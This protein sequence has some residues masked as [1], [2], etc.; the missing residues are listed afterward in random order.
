MELLGR[1]DDAIAVEV[2]GPGETLTYRQLDER[3]RALA[4]RLRA[5]GAGP[6]HIIPVAL[7]RGIELIVTLVGILR[8]GAAYAPMDPAT[9]QA[10]R[11]ELARL[12]GDAAQA[13]PHPARPSHPQDLAYLIF[14]SGSTGTPKAVAVPRSALDNHRRAMINA[15]GLTGRDR[16]VQFASPA[17]DVL[18][19]EVFPTLAVGARLVILPDSL[20]G[21]AEFERLV[22]LHGITVANL[23]T[24]YWTEWTRDLDAAPR[25]L[26]SSLRLLVIGS[27]GGHAAT[28]RS[29]RA[30]TSIPVINAYGLSETTITTAL[31][32]LDS[33]EVSDPLPIGSAIDGARLYVLDADLRPVAPG[34]IGEL[35]V[36]GAVLARGYLGRP[37]LTADRFVPDPYAPTPGERLYRTGDLVREIAGQGLQFLGRN[38]EQIKI[39]GHRVEPLEVQSALVSHPDVAAAHIT[40]YLD[41]RETRLVAYL[42]PGTDRRVPTATA[43]R[44]HLAHRLPDYFLPSAYVILDRLPLLPNGKVDRSALPPVS[45][46]RHAD[47]LTAPRTPTEEALARVWCEVLG[48]DA[49]GVDEDLF[50][51][52]GHSL[53]A[54]RLAARIHE[55]TGAGVTAVQILGAPTIAAV[56]E[57]VG[58]GDPGRLPALTGQARTTAPLSRQQEQVC[59]LTN[60]APHSIAYHTQ[61]TI[62]VAG[63]LDLEVLDRTIT[64]LVRR[65]AIFRTTY[66]LRDGQFQQHI[67]DPAP[68]A[69]RRVDLR[70]VAPEQRESEVEKHVAEEL[71]RPFDLTA[72]PLLRWTVLTLADD[73]HEIVLVEHHL[74]HDGW[75]FALLMREFKAIYNAYA[76]GEPSPLPEPTVQY[77]DY[78]A[79]QSRALDTGELADQLDYWRKRL[80]G[81]PAAL[82][83]HPDR[84]R[85]RV[86]TYRGGTLRIELPPTL[87]AAVRAFCRAERVTLF[88]AMYAAFAALMHRYTGVTDVCIGSAYANRQVPGTQKI[89]G[90]FVNAVLLRTDVGPDTAY[91]DLAHR[92]QE[93]ILSAADHQ[94]LPFTEL[95][96]VLNPD[97]D[98]AGQPLM[99]I[100]FSANDSPL[101]DLDLAG[102]AATVFERGNGSAKMDID[103]VVIPRAE[104]QT[105]DAEHV[106]DRIMLLWE[107]NADLYEESTMHHMIGHYLNLLAAAVA[108]PDTAVADLPLAAPFVEPHRPAAPFVPVAQQVRATPRQAIGSLS[109]VDLVGR[110]NGLA[111]ELQRR[112]TA[113]GDIVGVLLPRGERLVVAELGVLLAGAAFLPLDPGTPAAR[114]ALCCAD[115]GVRHVVCDETL[116]SLA[117]PGVTALPGD[118]AGHPSPVECGPHD[119][120]YVIYTSGSTGRPKGVMVEHGALS[121][122]VA[123]HTEAFALTPEDRITMVASPAFDASIG[124][125]WP[126][127]AAGASLHAPDDEVRLTPP[128]L[129]NWLAQK[130]ITVTDLPTPLTEALLALPPVQGRLRLM[131]TGGDRLTARP[132]ATLGYPLVNT[133]G[134]TE[135][136]VMATIGT[137]GPEGD[138]LPDIGRAV[139]GVTAYVLDSRLHQVPVGV[140]GE[141]YLGGACL[142]RGYLGRPDLTAESFL[143]DPFGDGGRIY[144]TGDR[145][146][147]RRD[148]TLEF[149]GR[150]DAQ[151]KV[152]GFR[153][154][155][156]EVAAW[157]IRHPRVAQAHV[158]AR[159]LQLVAYLVPSGSRADASELRAH[160]SAQLPPYMVP[161]AYVWLDHLPVTPHGKID[162]ARLPVAPPA[163]STAAAPGSPTE[164]VIAGIWRDTLGL[165]S[166]GV[167]DNFFDLGGHS[168]LLGQVHQRI[169][170]ELAPELPMVMLFQYPTIAA[171]AA[172]LDG[173][174]APVERTTPDE[175]GRNRLERLRALRGT[176]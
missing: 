40:S 152:R 4:R 14:T 81:M 161:S 12:A 52:G 72:L 82:T 80:D 67:H 56:A 162:A 115:A 37:D 154:E 175:E 86:Q 15:Y 77:H 145:V 119:L 94:E 5:E 144:R 130:A 41:G 105:A 11:E 163:P 88:A 24:P 111:A 70:A 116:S 149:L 9:P 42:V 118:Y 173:S 114:I 96:R 50:A 87:P 101:P 59:F 6:D 26:P 73:E 61:T 60:L 171:L 100:L 83:V 117:P 22:E 147:R 170:Q 39:R 109:Y 146:R 131:L 55:V 30:H 69:A 90:M 47:A 49:V 54:T 85:P 93:T 29:W 168:L 71:A 58:A 89:I 107:Y 151:L 134:P 123:W 155:P 17:F 141:L 98:V 128:R 156:A 135:A 103:V 1:T 121:N 104:S 76:A 74:V 51:L 25:D 79:W 66:H 122:L 110:A 48:L 167:H 132:S 78:A 142:A 45:G 129:R 10:R 91:R 138:G 31:A 124:E 35:Y 32:R 33:A 3:S 108:A 106:D 136:T 95:V 113:P 176:R 125:I 28:L 140:P 127:L 165:P 139:A 157:L 21:P 18:A 102:S 169:R 97:R 46:R 63:P 44:A 137:V 64:E 174:R 62:R 27:E 133:Y 126:A 65:H 150:T 172:H 36:G 160:L 57:L 34:Q 19:E 20:I 158:T 112:G 120:A 2:A 23:P 38:D 99:Q 75:S 16:V 153:I 68:A 8:S 43:I 166:V 164:Q 148:G 84:P 92:A 159:D 53:T 13:R 143:P 7:P